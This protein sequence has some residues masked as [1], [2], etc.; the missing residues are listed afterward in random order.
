M[1]GG[2]FILLVCDVNVHKRCE[3]NVPAL[4]GV[5]HTERRGR[6]HIKLWCSSDGTKKQLVV[7]VGEARNLIPMDP[8]VRYAVCSL[9]HFEYIGIRKLKHVYMT[10]R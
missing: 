10:R 5:D 7:E 2:L 3:S 9:M 8:N 6:V 4:C 1:F